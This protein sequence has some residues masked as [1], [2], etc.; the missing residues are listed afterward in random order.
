MQ[1]FNRSVEGCAGNPVLTRL[2]DQARVFSDS[3]RRARQL[4]KI[5]GDMTFGLDRYSSHRA[6]VRAL[7]AGDSA[8]A[9]AIVIND[10]RGGLSDLLNSPYPD[11]HAEH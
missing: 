10:A 11:T 8:A 9:E 3:E 4:E 5:A 6:L 2:L 1:R 7:R